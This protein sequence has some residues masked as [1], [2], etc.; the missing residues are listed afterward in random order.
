MELEFVYDAG[1]EI[2][3]WQTDLPSGTTDPEPPEAG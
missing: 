2:S 1:I 3:I